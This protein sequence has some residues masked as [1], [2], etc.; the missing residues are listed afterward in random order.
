MI[1]RV[2]GGSPGLIGS[3]SRTHRGKCLQSLLVAVGMILWDQWEMQEPENGV[4]KYRRRSVTQTT[5]QNWLIINRNYRKH[6]QN[7]VTSTSSAI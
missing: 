4:R 6:C 3:G 2:G 7:I 5:Q 1:M